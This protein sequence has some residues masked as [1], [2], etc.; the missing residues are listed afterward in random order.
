MFHSYYPFSEAYKLAEELCTNAKKLSRIDEGSYIDFHLHQSGSVSG[1]HRLRERQYKVDGLMI[2]RRPWRVSAGLDD[3][4]PN[5]KWFDD[6]IKVIIEGITKMPHKMPRNKIKAI[7]NAIGAGEKTAKIAINQMR[8][9]ELPEFSIRPNTGMS[10]YAQ[11]YDIL[12]FCDA[13]TNLLNKEE[14]NHAE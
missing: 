12:E 14:G 2:L 9:V 1:L 5:F 13:Y 6:S 4:W 11:Y 7:C 10:I 3:K 8:G